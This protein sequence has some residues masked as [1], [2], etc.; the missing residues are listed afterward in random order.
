MEGQDKKYKTGH[1]RLEQVGKR[2]R[3]SDRIGQDGSGTGKD[4]E[5]PRRIRKDRT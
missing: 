4:C 5:E 2:E 3:F 1:F